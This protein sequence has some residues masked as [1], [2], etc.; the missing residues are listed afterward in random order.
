MSASLF[1]PT[2]PW[3]V[4]PGELYAQ[5]AF[6]R[7]VRVSFTYRVP[8]HLRSSI[9][10]GKRVSVPFGRGNRQE[11]GYCVDVHVRPPTH[12]PIKE[13]DSIIDSKPLL[14]FS[15]LRLTEWMATYY[16][17]S[18]GQV[19][20]AVIPRAVKDSSGTR[21]A[22]EVAPVA[23]PPTDVSPL[24]SKQRLAWESLSSQSGPIFLDD[25]CRQA[26]VGPTVIRG[27]IDKGFAL[28]KKV[29]TK[30]SLDAVAP[31]ARTKPLELQKHQADACRQ[32]TQSIDAG[33]SARF[34]LHGVTGSGKTEVYL[35][36]ISHAVERGREAIV[37]VPEISLTPQ[38]I[39]RFRQ[40]FDSVAIL[41]SHLSD[42]ERHHHWQQI[43][44][45]KVQVVIGARSAIFA[46]CGKLGI[47]IIDEEHEGT[48]KQET[49]PRYHARDVAFFRA[50][51][52]SVPV[53]MGSATPSLESWFMSQR[54]ESI[55]LSLPER[56]GTMN[57][58]RV[59]AID[60]R[61]EYRQQRG[62]AA[63]GPTLSRE[64]RSCLDAGGQVILLL[65]RRGFAPALVCPQC[66]HVER[67]PHCDI[68]LTF[69]K[70][71]GQ[72]MCHSCDL[73]MPAPRQCSQCRHPEIRLTGFGTERL[74][75]EVKARF[76]GVPMARMDSDTMRSP[77]HY[78][79]VLSGFRAGEIK[80]LLGTQMIAKG[81]DF[82]NVRLV[83][84]ISADTARH[85]PDFRSTEKTFQIIVQVAGRAGRGEQAGRVVVQTFNPQDPTIQLAIR[86]DYLAFVRRELPDRQAGGYPPYQKLTRIIVRAKE[87]SAARAAAQQIAQ[88]LK[89][90]AGLWP[91]VVIKGPA[92]APVTKLRDFF[93]FHLQIHTPD[94]RT[95]E[96][97]LDK[98]LEDLGLPASVEYAVD[99][100]PMD[101]L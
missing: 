56:I 44:E 77:G 88:K 59:E 3:L 60:L 53:V 49:T 78:E 80:I 39:E 83:G 63:V 14:S 9:L 84:V 40:R 8:E 52:E 87:E 65:N 16:F 45:G 19:L 93:R 90:T 24:S 72:T 43:R 79:S 55:L 67:C 47:I 64:M 97:L 71:R 41:H 96:Q 73:M 7:P 92:P 101:L 86:Q 22:W 13:L 46:P 74:E 35:Q 21:W 26:R 82:P 61:E 58:P 98:G 81:L 37:L 38:T 17:C 32:I 42:S 91:G 25:L 66:G 75:D 30:T 76:P 68:T 28:T 89:Q 6:A 100:D 94:S 29:R 69:H 48:F 70:H 5:V 31:I 23:S 50:Q 2:L 4:E 27:L 54:G 99:C 95:R 1:E 12:H 33:V 11:V 51:Q 57:L 34:L 15:M 85:L 36:A 10:A 62:L 18:W 20:D